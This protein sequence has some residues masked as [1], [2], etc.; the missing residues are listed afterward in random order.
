MKF[1]G[2]PHERT[3]SFLL[4]LPRSRIAETQE[5]KKDD[6]QLKME[7]NATLADE[8]AEAKANAALNAEVTAP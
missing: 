4:T 1:T 7:L 6:A 2:F 8:A 5:V 3:L